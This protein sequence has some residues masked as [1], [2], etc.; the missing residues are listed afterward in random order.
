MIALN[1]RRTREAIALQSAL[2][3][4]D[5]KNRVSREKPMKKRNEIEEYL[6]SRELSSVFIDGFDA[7]IIGLL[8]RDDIAIVAYSEEKIINKLISDGFSHEDAIEYFEYNIVNSYIGDC[9]PI[10]IQTEF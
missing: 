1:N 6:S 2:S 9:T 4:P 8:F 7:A 3:L 5:L 10:I